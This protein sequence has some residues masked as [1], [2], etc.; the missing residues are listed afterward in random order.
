M[1]NLSND[2]FQKVNESIA[3]ATQAVAPID[4]TS[5]DPSMTPQPNPEASPFNVPIQGEHPELR[6]IAPITWTSLGLGLKDMAM[7]IPKAPIRYGYSLYQAWSNFAKGKTG[8]NDVVEQKPLDIPVIG[9]V[10]SYWKSFK[11]MRDSGVGPV[12]SVALS[13]LNIGGDIVLTSGLAETVTKAFQPRMVLKP[14]ETVQ[15]IEPIKAALTQDQAGLLKGVKKT[16]SVSEY[17]SLPKSTAKDLG[18]KPN[19]TFLKMTPAGPGQVEMAVVEVRNAPTQKLYDAVTRKSTYKGDFGNEV[20][21]NSQII[22]V[23]KVPEAMPAGTPAITDIVPP[24][25]QITSIPPRALKGFENKLVMPDQVANLDLIGRV[26][27]VEPVVQQSVIKTLTGKDA[28]GELTQSEYVNVA[29]TIANLKN[30]TKYAPDINVP[31]AERYVSPARYWMR[32]METQHGFPIYSEGYVPMEDASRLASVSEK[33][34]LSTLYEDPI[35]QKYSAGKYAEERRLVR[36]YRTGNTAAITD[37]PSLSPATKTELIGAAQKFDQYYSQLGPDVGVPP[38]IFLE[39]YSP[40]ISDVGGKFQL[41]KEKGKIPGSMSFFAKEKRVGSL[42]TQID[43]E[44]ALAEI[45]TRAGYKAKYLDPVLK[46]MGNYFDQ[47]P[48]EIRNSFSSY[49][50]EKLGYGGEVEKWIDGI[51]TRLNEKLGWN[52][53][54]DIARRAMNQTMN[55]MYSSA[56]SQPATVFRN[57]FQYPIMGYAYWGNKFMP[58]AIAKTLTSAG[59]AEFLK[60]GFSVDLGVPFGQELTEQTVG[61][62]IATGY[63]SLTQGVL[64]PNSIVENANRGFM[65]HQSKMIFDDAIAR[66]NSGKLNWA[67]VEKELGLNTM[68]KLDANVIRQK[69][70][71]GDLE[72]ARNQVIRNA[73]DDTQFPYRRGASMRLSYGAPGHV[74]TAFMQWPVEYFHTLKTWTATGQ[75]DKLARWFGASTLILRSMKDL[76]MDFSNSLYLNPIA[77]TSLSP[78]VKVASQAVQGLSNWLNDNQQELAGNIDELSKEMKLA[79]P[80]GLEIKNINTMVDSVKKGAVGPNGEYGVYDGSGRLKYYATFPELFLNALGMPIQQKVDNAKLTTDIMNKQFEYSQAKQKA[81]ELFQQGDTQNAVDIITKY[82]IQLS[83]GDFDKYYI[84][85]NQNM[86]D[87]LPA[88]LKA[89]FAPRI[90]K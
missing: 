72:G 13:A 66:Y 39:N 57:S 63:K 29:Q 48:P 55:T 68:N 3:S 78:A 44:W 56:M 88:Q 19:T 80:A 30:S 86:F 33:T 43:D 60:S 70:V 37:N 64:K 26:N 34:Q 42:A 40:H 9:Q 47:L 38:E 35:I 28:V 75:W 4:P 74:S 54:P 36:A 61:G 83:P 45:Y 6:K 20:K 59:R 89:E 18:G 79:Y 52:L 65:Y 67:G 84:P 17:Y 31:L 85:F 69:L 12:A 71:A 2:Y 46:R 81:L 8:L 32:D 1:G 22:D 7:E 25:T 41:Y 76:G 23:S 15:N 87:S 62:K 24:K 21:L 10:S 14:G 50:Q 82:G 27:G 90:F 53:P 5:S 73:I 51:G 58:Q 11:D 77:N 16:D 49:V